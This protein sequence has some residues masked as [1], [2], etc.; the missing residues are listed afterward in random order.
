MANFCFKKI[1]ISSKLNFEP[2]LEYSFIIFLISLISVSLIFLIPD[3]N[4]V[5]LGFFYLV[6][7][8]GLSIVLMFSRGR[9]K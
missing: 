2:S 1:L 4:N 7:P 6:L 5:Y 8:R 9:F 3:M